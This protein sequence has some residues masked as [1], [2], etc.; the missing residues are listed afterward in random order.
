M[1]GI[2]A[3]IWII[4]AIFTGWWAKAYEVY[5]TNRAVTR[6]RNADF[7]LWQREEAR[8]SMLEDAPRASFIPDAREES[9]A[10]ALR[11]I[12]DDVHSDLTGQW[13]IVTRF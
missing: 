8:A 4:I 12:A 7:D 6:Q 2:D 1:T 10:E 3:T 5:M 9:G 13:Y 11:D